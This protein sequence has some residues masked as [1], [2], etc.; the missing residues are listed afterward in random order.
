MFIESI[1]KGY[2]IAIIANIVKQVVL[3]ESISYV[4]LVKWKQCV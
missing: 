1:L 3:S 4:V 2:K